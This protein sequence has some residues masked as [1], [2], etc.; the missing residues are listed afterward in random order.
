MELSINLL[1]WFAAIGCGL[2]AGIYFAFST[3]IMAA[4][5]RIDE[6]GGIAAM[7]SINATILG[8]LFMPLF[9]GTTLASVALVILGLAAWGQPGSTV[10]LAG[11]LIHV[12]GMFASTLVF[13]VPLNKELTRAGEGAADV[14]ARY[15]KKWTFWNHVRTVASTVACAGFIAALLARP[16][17]F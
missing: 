17:V 3:F 16:P 11:G 9:F 7:N 5:G 6:G 13:N 1:L 2:I 12:I 15:L 8:S 14:W 10:M 4:L